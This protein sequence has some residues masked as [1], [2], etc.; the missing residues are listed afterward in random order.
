[1][2][3]IGPLG[4]LGLMGLLG[5][6]SGRACRKTD[7]RPQTSD[8]FPSLSKLWFLSKSKHRVLQVIQ[9]VLIFAKTKILMKPNYLRII[10]VV[11][12]CFSIGY[13]IPSLTVK[14]PYIDALFAVAVVIL[15]ALMLYSMKKGK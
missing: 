11:A 5:N 14:R 8:F 12:L 9:K 10:I 1:M 15:F 6:T 13:L 7:F 3:L 4:P 2:S